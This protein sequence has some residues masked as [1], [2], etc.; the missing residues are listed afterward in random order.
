MISFER[1]GL[2]HKQIINSAY[3]HDGKQNSEYSFAN[4][5]MWGRQQVAVVAGC[6]C[7]FSHWN[8]KSLYLYPEGGDTRAALTALMADSQERGIPLRLYGLSRQEVEELEGFFPGEFY[9]KPV[10]D[11]FDYVYD[12]A[13][14]ADLKGKKLQQKRNHINRFLESHPDWVS[15]PI[16]PEL[17]PEC[18]QMV[19]DWYQ[20]HEQTY[21]HGDFDLEQRAISRCFDNYQALDMEGLVLR[22]EP[23]G[24]ILALT[25]G[26]RTSGD[27]FDVNYEKAYSDVQG[28]YPLVNRT[29][30]RCLQAKY[31]ELRYLNREDDMGLPGLRK[32]KESYHPDI[33]AEKYSAVW[34]QE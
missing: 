29:F 2:S 7:V 19:A 9:C 24:R 4:L 27:T 28:A 12:I 20:Y 26:N 10:R 22:G 21:G 34:M 16:T 8:N 14:L 18:R 31:P 13:R 30:A 33:L 15:Q 3:F 1:V 5:F 23:N 25:M 17:L 6:V 11:S 32:A